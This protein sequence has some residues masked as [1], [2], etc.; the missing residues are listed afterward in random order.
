MRQRFNRCAIRKYVNIVYYSRKLWKC[1]NVTWHRTLT[2]THCN[3]YKML[4]LFHQHGNLTCPKFQGRTQKRPTVPSQIRPVSLSTY[5][6]RWLS[7][8]RYTWSSVQKSIFIVSLKSEPKNVWKILRDLN[9][10]LLAK[11]EF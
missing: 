9:F 1:Y 4:C 2:C 10:V 6:W 11:L 3:G 8:S 7:S 5:S